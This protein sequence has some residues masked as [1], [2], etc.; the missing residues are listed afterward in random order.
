[1]NHAEMVKVLAKPGE[2]IRQTCTP[3]QCHM[4]HMAIGLSGEVGELMDAVIFDPLNKENILEELGDI[5]FY[6]QG[7]AQ[8]ITDYN[9]IYCSSIRLY[10]PQRISVSEAIIK[11]S[12]KASQI[13]DVIKKYYIYQKDYDKKSLVAF[14]CK[15]Q[16]LL[17]VIREYNGFSREDTRVHNISKLSIRYKNFQYSD[18]AAQNRADKGEE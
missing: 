1:M 16:C 7:L 5:E 6:Y 14:M 9:E 15:L 18:E 10:A 4:I 17:Q 2:T 3:H 13:L 11:S 12:I 8:E